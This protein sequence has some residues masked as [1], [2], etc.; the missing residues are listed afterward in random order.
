ME[1]SED[2]FNTASPLL[3]LKLG[4][5]TSLFCG[6][7]VSPKESTNNVTVSAMINLQKVNGIAEKW[8][9]VQPVSL[10][11]KNFE[12]V[13]G[14]IKDIDTSKKEYAGIKWPA[15]AS[16]RRNFSN[17]R[18]LETNS[19]LSVTTEQ[20]CSEERDGNE[21]NDEKESGEMS[22]SL[23]RSSRGNI[24]YNSCFRCAIKRT[25]FHFERV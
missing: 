12:L 18:K 24:S 15:H 22:T 4:D 3:T 20:T 5:K 17:E 21:D 14:K 19:K 10:Y 25:V 11:A 7:L 2:K 23:R 8:S 13:W 16:C 1:Q 6:G 9:K